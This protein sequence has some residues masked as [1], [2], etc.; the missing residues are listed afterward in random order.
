ML[1][2]R[3]SGSKWV[4]RKSWMKWQTCF[5]TTFW[6][7]DHLY[8]SCYDQCGHEFFQHNPSFRS[9]YHVI[10]HALRGA[11]SVK[12]YNFCSKVEL[13][14]FECNQTW[15]LWR[16][17]KLNLDKLNFNFVAFQSARKPLSTSKTFCCHRRFNV[18]ICE[19]TFTWGTV[20]T[21]WW[22]EYQN[23]VND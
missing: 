15:P 12:D 16:V 6:Q 10:N 23:Y 18:V 3:P 9:P 7:A 8:A 13:S 19:A 21:P 1:A 11:N 2:R 5:G 4:S 14:H 20:K 17:L 22:I